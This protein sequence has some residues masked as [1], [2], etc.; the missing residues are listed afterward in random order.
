MRSDCC[1]EDTLNNSNFY[2]RLASTTLK[3]S[4]VVSL[5]L[6]HHDLLHYLPIECNRE[7]IEICNSA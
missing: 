3:S 4:S 7:L 6:K 5:A 1:N 2:P